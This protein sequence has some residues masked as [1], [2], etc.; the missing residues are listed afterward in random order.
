MG[1][2][3]K[4]GLLEFSIP[5]LSEELDYVNNELL[6]KY[7]LYKKN[8][9]TPKIPKKNLKEDFRNNKNIYL[10]SLKEIKKFKKRWKRVYDI[11]IIIKKKYNFKIFEN[12]EVRLTLYGPGG[13]YFP[14]YGAF[15]GKL[16]NQPGRTR[17]LNK[18]IILVRADLKKFFERII[19]HEIIH[20]GIEENI[21][22]K[23]KLR[24]SEKES[25]VNKIYKRYFGK[26]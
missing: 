26:S 4:R 21:V 8:G 20:L 9:Y 18:A 13:D 23:N 1:N 3:V 16:R 12:Y 15:D 6:K 2:K 14:S 25:L 19:I 11:L 10:N 22:R 7:S 17:K 5:S 24:H